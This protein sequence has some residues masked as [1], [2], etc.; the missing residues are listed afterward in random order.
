LLVIHDE[1]N[2]MKILPKRVSVKNELSS[3]AGK[4]KEDVKSRINLQPAPD[5]ESFETNRVAFLVLAE[6][7][8]GNQKTA[9]DKEE[10]HARPSRS[11]KE[12]GN[13][14]VMDHHGDDRHTAEDI[15]PFVS[16]LLIFA[17]GPKGASK[18]QSGGEIAFSSSPERSVLSDLGAISAG[19]NFVAAFIAR[20]PLETCATSFQEA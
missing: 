20:L 19:A 15:Q 1:E 14:R 11:R 5:E 3:D 9:E 13:V 18:T 10:I 12:R 16:H 2:V 7:Q 8:T 17:S 4:E 6:E